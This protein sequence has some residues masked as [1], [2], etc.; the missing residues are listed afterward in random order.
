[1][2]QFLPTFTSSKN[3]SLKTTQGLTTLDEVDISSDLE[4][5]YQFIFLLDRSGSMSGNRMKYANEAVKLFLKS[6]PSESHFGI[7]SFG[8]KGYWE[9]GGIQ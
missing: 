9:L 1:M 4:F 6:L 5:E 3:D 8:F 2:A 7:Y